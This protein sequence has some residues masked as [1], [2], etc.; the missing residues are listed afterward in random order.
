M[1][2]MLASTVYHWIA[3]GTALDEALRRAIGLFPADVAVGLIAVSR[4][5]SGAFSN[6]PMPQAVVSHG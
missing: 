1:R 6:Q 2:H 5:E 3:A 4:T